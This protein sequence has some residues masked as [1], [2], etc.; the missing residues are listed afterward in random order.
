MSTA[1]KTGAQVLV[2]SIQNHGVEYIF[3]L[4]GGA[5]IPIF[6]ALVDSPVELVLTRHEQGAAHMADGF[7]R[8]TGKP[9]V[10]L[11]TSGPG[12]TNTI[13]GI[14]TAHM[15]SVP[16]I[17]LCGQ[18]TTDNLGL[19][20]F[21]EADVSGIS[22]PLVKHSYLIKDI[23]DLPRI[24]HEAFYLAQSGRP[25]PVLIDIPKDV[26]AAFIDCDYDEAFQ[27]PGYT[28]PVE[29]DSEDIQRA[30]LLLERARRPLLLVGHGAVISGAEQAIALFAEQMK[31]PVT[32]SLLGKGG[33]S[34]T[35]PLSLGMLGMHGTA[36]ANMAVQHCDL[37]MSIGARW[38]D[39][40][41]GNLEKFCPD[42]VKM[43]IDIDPSEFNK[44]LHMDCTILGDA[45]HVVKSLSSI[46]QPGDTRQWLEQVE[47]WK[48]RYPLKYNKT[49]KLR[50]EHAIDEIY[51][52]SGGHA[53][54]ATDVGQ[55]Q[56]WA[57]QYFKTNDRFHWISSGGAG[58]MGF[59]F[60]A[61]IG[62]QFAHPGETVIA[63]V[64]DGGFQ[65][66]L[67]ELSTAVV[68]KLPI[69]IL[70]I[71]N[72]Y[73]GMVRQWQS[74][75]YDNR[76]SGV[77]LQGNPDFIKL[78][79]SYGCR[80]YRISRSE[81]VQRTIASALEYREGPCLID[82]EVER[83]DNVFPMIPSGASYAEMIIEAPKERV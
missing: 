57:A 67:Y 14:L 33:F 37:I 12:A 59:G 49:G 55:H 35:H 54:V 71:N 32:N 58:T 34:E 63:V 3:G 8:A 28:V 11:V 75:F 9:G 78:A 52:Q 38:D 27:L 19:D 61:A 83:G 73:L 16:M 66:T 18:Q 56:M 68:H 69:K 53:Y 48:Q 65:M 43:H 22:F 26:A 51:Q 15:D 64:G 76:L 30:A 23:Q 24:I 70:L 39:R 20:A 4:P 36:Y 77:E 31:I 82:V 17:I 74:L 72:N 13:T 29:G 5:A 60:P 2:E 50:A 44:T 81:D 45:R 80:A 79:E 1:K 6:D 40:I 41:V 10:V 7:A 21:Q 25:G 62:A 47:E 46:V 42:A